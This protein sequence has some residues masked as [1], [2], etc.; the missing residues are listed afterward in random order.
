MDFID[1]LKN[2]INSIPNM[3]IQLRKGYL[4]TDESLVIYPLPGGQVSREYYD[5]TKDE[6]LNYELAMRSNDGNKIE[7]TL[8]LISDYI[9]RI[10]TIESQDQSFE[11]N[12]LRVTS[13][14]FINEANE[15]NWF[16]FL[17]DFQVSL[18]TFKEEN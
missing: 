11:F 6:L 4:T 2:K 16:I 13:K 14:P 1:Q 12:S 7:Q 15:Q 17:L 5:G 9:E 3:P 18:T 8:W 10:E